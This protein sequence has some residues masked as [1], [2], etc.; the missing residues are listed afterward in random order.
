M[1]KINGKFEAALIHGNRA[2]RTEDHIVIRNSISQ[3]IV[4]EDEPLFLLRA[5]DKYAVLV[6][7]EYFR[8]ISGDPEIPSMARDAL[9][10]QVTAFKD[11]T[12]KQRQRMKSPGTSMPAD[13]EK[14]RK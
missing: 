11:F 9:W 13:L 6:L 12:V 4:P 1:R 3:E 5:R 2:A 8:Y 7:L 14:L 10:E